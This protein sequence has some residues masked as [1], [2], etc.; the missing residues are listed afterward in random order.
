MPDI[1]NKRANTIRALCVLA[2]CWLSGCSPRIVIKTYQLSPDLIYQDR[3]EPGFQELNKTM[4][5]LVTQ[6]ID[7]DGWARNGGHRGVLSWG[8]GKLYIATTAANHELIATMF[9]NLRAERRNLRQ[10]IPTNDAKDPDPSQS[11]PS[12]AAR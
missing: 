11:P 1:M 7:P 10:G 4:A 8:D 2:T 12:P 9:H 5:D 3:G 6:A